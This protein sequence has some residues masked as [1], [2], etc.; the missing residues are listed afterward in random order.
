VAPRTKN[1]SP[2]ISVSSRAVRFVSAC[3]LLPTVL[4]VLSFGLGP[5]ALAADATPSYSATGVCE[6]GIS[7]LSFSISG[8]P[9]VQQ[10]TIDFAVFNGPDDVG[11]SQLTATGPD[12]T[13]LWNLT[14]SRDFPP[15]TEDSVKVTLG[16]AEISPTN[17]IP[18]YD[19]SPG[20]Q[21][22]TV[23]Q[24]ICTSDATLEVNGS[25]TTASGLGY[26]LTT[27][28]GQ[29]LGFGDAMYFGSMSGVRLNHQVV[30]IASTPDSGGYWLVASD[31]GIFTF[32]D[33]QFYGSTGALH[34][35]KPIVGMA[36]TSDGKGYFLVASDGGVFAFGDA[37]FQGSMGGIQLNKPVV[38]MSLDRATEGYWLV[39]SDGGIFSFAA[40]FFGSTGNIHLN[41]PI[42]GMES[43]DGSGYRFVASDGG[44]FAFGDSGFLGSL[45]GDPPTSPVVSI[46]P[47]ST[48]SGYS[49]FTSNGGVYPFGDADNFG[50]IA[51]ATTL[52]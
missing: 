31:G 32:G 20:N 4:T 13:A 26:W 12:V 41:R 35:D 7:D 28:D 6:N 25:A 10:S 44:I 37:K 27:P 52:Q 50:S 16:N 36:P 8:L 11:S 9:S 18:S 51:G 46:S 23:T 42:V 2:K 48:D 21:Y 29:V 34:L 33:A 45:G 15:G 19:L 5:S 14:T 47:T 43:Q 49:E 38:G 30:G 24:P 1:R 3:I 22:Y 39:A 40:P 17:L